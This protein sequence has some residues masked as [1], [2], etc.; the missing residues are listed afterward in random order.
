M[1][2][3]RE[4][5]SDEEHQKSIASEEEVLPLPVEEMTLHCEHMNNYTNILTDLINVDVEIEEEDKAAFFLN[6]L[7]DEECET[8]VLSLVNGKQSFS[9]NDVST[10]LINYEVKRKDK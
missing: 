6:S 5:V 2:H 1:G 8:F 7:P 10:A 9:N 4:K 3:P